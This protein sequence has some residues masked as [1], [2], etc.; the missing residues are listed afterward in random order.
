[1]T[2]PSAGTQ[3]ACLEQRWR[4]LIPAPARSSDAA[5]AALD[6][7]L[8]AYSAPGR[9]Y[10]S[11]AHIAALLRLTASQAAQFKDQTSVDLAIF[12][13]DAIYDIA[14][15]DNEAQS[16]RLAEA[17]LPPLGVTPAQVARIAALIEATA[18][19][20]ANPDPKDADLLR[21]LDLDLSILAA[22]RNAYARYAAAIRAEYAVYPDPVYRLGRRRVLESF[23]ARSRI[24]ACDDLDAIWDAPAR[25]NLRWEISILDSGQPLDVPALEALVAEPKTAS[26]DGNGD[27]G[28]SLSDR[29]P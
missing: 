18:H 20:V 25:D 7:L 12:Y 22:S 15:K 2:D 10:H 17:R 28:R 13:H 3:R 29:A 23:L 26:P 1:M 9:H 16:A 5:R 27:S 24:Y 4:E 11:L 6:E 8:A 14:R 21:F 19:G